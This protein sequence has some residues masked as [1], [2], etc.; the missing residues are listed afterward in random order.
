[1]R[2]GTRLVKVLSFDGRSGMSG[3]HRSKQGRGKVQ[4]AAETR[5][6]ARRKT[7][8]AAEE[9]SPERRL[10]LAQQIEAKRFRGRPRSI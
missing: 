8:S 10:E 1:M 4:K 5:G 9:L 2:F 7:T 3:D 6:R